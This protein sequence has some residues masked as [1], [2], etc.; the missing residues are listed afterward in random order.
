MNIKIYNHISLKDT[1]KLTD[2]EVVSVKDNIVVVKKNN[3]FDFFTLNSKNLSKQ[4]NLSYPY[5]QIESF[6][7]DLAI[8]KNE[9]ETKSLVT[10]DHIEITRYN[11]IVYLE[12]GLYKVKKDNKWGII[13]KSGNIILQINFSKINEFSHG[14]CIIEQGGL[15]GMV[16][17]QGK[18]VIPVYYEDISDVKD[19]KVIITQFIKDKTLNSLKSKFG[20]KESLKQKKGLIDIS[21]KVLI[22][23]KYIDMF[24]T[25]DNHILAEA[26]NQKFIKMDYAGKVLNKFS[27]GNYVIYNKQNGFVVA[28]KESF[29]PTHLKRSVFDSNGNK[30]FKDNYASE[31]FENKVIIGDDKRKNYLIDNAGKII[32]KKYDLIANLNHNLQLLLVENDH[33]LGLIDYNGKEII[34]PHYKDIMIINKNVYVVFNYGTSSLFNRSGMRISNEYDYISYFNNG[35]A[36]FRN[37]SEYGLIDINGNEIFNC[38]EPIDSYYKLGN[39]I[40]IYYKDRLDIISINGEIIVE[41]IR[42]SVQIVN[43]EQLLVNGCLININDIKIMPIYCDIETDIF[44]A[45]DF[46]SWLKALAYDAEHQKIINNLGQKTKKKIK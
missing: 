25:Y 20:R 16:D 35:V 12:D 8:V 30:I 46:T 24:F 40:I 23:P 19:G 42:Q 38:Y 9:D 4:E 31:L 17:K 18:I 14:V 3:K 5:K 21:G 34:K 45:T 37:G 36:L 15:K 11:S 43:D 10:T 32:S 26:K 28:R 27:L 2:D 13:D 22:E 44:K 33:K 41:N 6:I 29:F 7:N 1:F 39:L